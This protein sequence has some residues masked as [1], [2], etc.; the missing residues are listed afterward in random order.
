[1]HAPASA[2]GDRRRFALPASLR[3]AVP[4]R[5]GAPILK[6]VGMLTG[7]VALSGVLLVVTPVAHPH[8]TVV[9]GVTGPSAARITR[10]LE[11]EASKHSTFAPSEDALMRAVAAYPEV[12]GVAI[13][14]QPPFRVEVRAL[15]RPPV[16]RIDL[17][18]R[19]FVVAGDGTI[20]QRAVEADVPQL[21]FAVGAVTLRD[22]RV[23]GSRAALQ[24][25]AGAPQPLLAIARAARTTRAG[26]EVEMA[27]GPRLIF[28][29]ATQA[30]DK[31]AAAAAVIADGSAQAA[32]YIDLRVP[33]RPAVGGLGGSK[34]A[35]DADPPQLTATQ[36]AP[37]TAASVA[38]S[39]APT[40]PS[41]GSTA[42]TARAGAAVPPA[43]TQSAVGS[44]SGTA[45]SAA[46]SP[47]AAPAAAAPA[48][49]STATSSSPD[50]GG[51]AIGATP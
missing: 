47:A 13:D 34:S 16:A 30:A 12:A 25:L 35:T 2:S 29:S 8:T 28:G 9:D 31:W 32:T 36:T 51:A 10:L 41:A 20:L 39:T 22:G 1:M 38:T 15:M 18:G 19:A 45:Q 42:A 7:L 11:D 40:A 43:S 27:R 49:A 46:P 4:L 14:A 37:G 3:G 48:P 21:E 24:V 26:I 50:G 6:A 44:A 17:A 23:R 5:G 33:S